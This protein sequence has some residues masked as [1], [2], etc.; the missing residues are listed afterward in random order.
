MFPN[1]THACPQLLFTLVCSIKWGAHH[2]KRLQ[3]INIGKIKRKKRKQSEFKGTKSTS[4]KNPIELF[5]FNL[6]RSLLALFFTLWLNRYIS[7]PIFC[8]LFFFFKVWTKVNCSWVTN[9]LNGFLTVLMSCYMI[10]VAFYSNNYYYN[11]YFG[12]PP[13]QWFKLR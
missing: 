1:L 7:W 8:C 4:V 12:L 9:N 10:D 11:C 3:G 2:I 6:H 13:I 5:G